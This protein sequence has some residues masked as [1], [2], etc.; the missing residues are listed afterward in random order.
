MVTIKLAKAWTYYTPQTTIE[1]PAGE[2]EVF[3]Y[4]ADAAEADGAIEKDAN[5]GSPR[6]SATRS[7]KGAAD[8][9]QV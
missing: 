2:H 6:E 9:G 1:Y 7:K 8:G 5:D 3:Q 4:I